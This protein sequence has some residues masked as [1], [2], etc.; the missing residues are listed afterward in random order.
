M[1]LRITTRAPRRFA[2][3]R[4]GRG[5]VVLVAVSLLAVALVAGA[6]SVVMLVLLTVEAPEAG[7][8]PSGVAVLVAALAVAVVGMFLGLRLLRGK[9]RLVLFLRRFGLAEA[10]EAVT[11]AVTT[12][13]GRSWRVVTL[14]DD[15]ISPVGVPTST[16]R[17][18]A[19]TAVVGIAVLGVGLVWFV[20]SG[21]IDGLL[22]A[23]LTDAIDQ[24]VT[25]T[26]RPA[27]PQQALESLITGVFTA[28][29]V[30]MAVGAVVMMLILVALVAMAFFGVSGLFMANAYRTARR[31]EH[32]KRAVVTD[33]EEIAAIA[34]DLSHRSGGIF[35]S[36]L[37]VLTVAHP[38]WRDAVR[39]LAA[40]VPV[41]LIDISQPTENLLWEVETLRR[42][43]DTTWVLIG[44]RD[45]VEALADGRMEGGPT[46]AAVRQ[47]AL[48]LDGET[49]L[50][51][52]DGRRAIRRFA[53]A[54]RASLD[55]AA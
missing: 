47:L 20:A 3:R 17:S 13:M 9:R 4:A 32:G 44:E 51:Y 6:V 40:V 14:D 52:E 48:L 45:H 7:A 39:A 41:V 49:V 15:E 28:L 43:P 29:V 54:L 31:A 27:G 38:V 8:D 10:T 24:A 30:G 53:R 50:A 26:E 55:A 2:V 37:T 42:Q 22:D 11:V 5:L 33:G 12:A 19:T 25:P 34:D 21:G 23:A 35:R 46:D 18:L 16:R 36:R 1:A